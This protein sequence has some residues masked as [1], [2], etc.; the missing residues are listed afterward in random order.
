MNTADL[1]T[2]LRYKLSYADYSDYQITEALNYVIKEISEALNSVSSSL[3]NTSATLTLTDNEADLPS[4]L[5]T[6]IYVTDKINIPI[7][8]ELDAFTY[9]IEGNTIRTE[10]DTVTIYYRKT[11][12]EY[13]FDGTVITPSTIDLPASFNNMIKTNIIAFL[14]GQPTDIKIQTIKLIANR[15]GKKR[16]QRLIFRL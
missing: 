13:T 14:A 8:D 5:E 4:D 7:T 12:P 11:L 1:L 3:I 15:D 9:Q 6:I 2:S 10:G 16:R